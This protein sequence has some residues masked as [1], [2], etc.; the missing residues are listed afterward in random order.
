MT[1]APSAMTAANS[2]GSRAVSPS[3]NRTVAPDSSG[4]NNSSPE[5]SN[6]TV[7][8]AT[9]TSS[10]PSANRSTMSSR[11]LTNAPDGITTPLGR[12]V[13]PEV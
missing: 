6:P 11:K 7:V 9:N 10:A 1:V 3:T 12:P 13:E 2:A 8:T 4:T 5:M